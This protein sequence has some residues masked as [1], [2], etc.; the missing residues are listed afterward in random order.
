MTGK[1][2]STRLNMDKL[3]DR[4]VDEILSNLPSRRKS[5]EW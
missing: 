1:A 5:E 2:I 3:T 4:K